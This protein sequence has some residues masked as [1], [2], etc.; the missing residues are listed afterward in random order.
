[1]KRIV[2]LAAVVMIFLGAGLLV[3]EKNKI[4]Q[5]QIEQSDA[6]EITS[7]PMKG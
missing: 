1:M 7:H 3:Q 5:N 2:M 6:F 4:E